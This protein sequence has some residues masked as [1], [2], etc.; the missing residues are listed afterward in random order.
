MLW[1]Q[2]LLPLLIVSLNQLRPKYNKKGHSGTKPESLLRKHI[3]IKK[4]QWNEFIPGFIE[5]YTVH[6]CDETVAGQY[7]LT[8]HY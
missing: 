2:S 4:D 8:I 3:P 1:N 5:S 7:A 6:H